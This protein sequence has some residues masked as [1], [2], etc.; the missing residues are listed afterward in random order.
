VRETSCLYSSP[1]VILLRGS[2][3]DIDRDYARI[4]KLESDGSLYS[5]REKEEGG[6]C[7]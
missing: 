5:E 3:E 7:V 1:G 6:F 4:R 2:T